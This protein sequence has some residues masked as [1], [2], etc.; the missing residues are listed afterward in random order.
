MAWTI[1]IHYQTG[2][3]FNSYE[4]TGSV[5]ITWEKL[6]V[7]KAALKRIREL[8]EYDRANNGWNTQSPPE[9]PSWVKKNQYGEINLILPLD[10]GSEH[11]FYAFWRGYFET[12]HIA[13]IVSQK[14]E[15][16]D[17]MNYSPGSF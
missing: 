11:E 16:D 13:M 4:D 9:L 2:D 12:L 1:E 10:D 15:D 8:D 5:E 17:D 6:D 3:S 14:P 7:A